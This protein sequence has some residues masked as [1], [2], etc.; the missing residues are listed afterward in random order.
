MG[1]GAMLRVCG[2]SLASR[3]RVDTVKVYSG[4][5]CHRHSSGT[6][7]LYG[8]F[9][10]FFFVGMVRQKK[11]TIKSYGSAAII[12]VFLPHPRITGRI[13]LLHICK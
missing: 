7:A 13:V 11:R 12:A 4:T 10:L 1:R 5:S 8:P 2:Y 9:F 3:R 6:V